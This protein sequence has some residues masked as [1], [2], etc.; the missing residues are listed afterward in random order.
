MVGFMIMKLFRGIMFAKQHG[1]FF[2][3]HCGNIIL[4]DIYLSY[5]CCCKIV[6]ARIKNDEL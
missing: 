6:V 3:E 5:K 2:F 4:V 1:F